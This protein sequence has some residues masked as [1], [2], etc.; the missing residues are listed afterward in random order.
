MTS[1]NG[2][3][4]GAKPH[5]D[6]RVYTAWQP[7]CTFGDVAVRFP[8]LHVARVSRVSPQ[9]AER[10]AFYNARWALR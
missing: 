4:A 9:Q 7:P 10:E 3:S 6:D 5:R 2:R 8:L 1:R